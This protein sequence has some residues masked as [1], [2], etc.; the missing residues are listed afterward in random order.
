MSW[1]RACAQL[2]GLKRCSP[3]RLDGTRLCKSCHCTMPNSAFSPSQQKGSSR[4]ML[5]VEIAPVVDACLHNRCAYCKT[6]TYE[7]LTKEHVIPKS[8]GGSWSP[9]LVCRACNQERKNSME[10]LPFKDM[11]NKFPV[12]MDHANKLEVSEWRWKNTC[13]PHAIKVLALSILKNAQ[14][15]ESAVPLIV[16]FSALAAHHQGTTLLDKV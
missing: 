7:S 12:L 3:T 15:H 16:S 10:F 13:L 9:K 5:C 4:C 11:A 2:A 6:V 14:K 1:G 8:K